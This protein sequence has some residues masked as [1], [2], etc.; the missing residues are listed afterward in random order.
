MQPADLVPWLCILWRMPEFARCLR[1]YFER[2]C[3]PAVIPDAPAPPAWVK[4]AADALA[5]TEGHESFESLST[6]ILNRVASLPASKNGKKG[7]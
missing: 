6:R 3:Q 2:E 5:K 7:H 1:D 4:G